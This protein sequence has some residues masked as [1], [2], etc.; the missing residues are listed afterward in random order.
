M[1]YAS[2][3]AQCAIYLTA[4]PISCPTVSAMA[5]RPASV[6]AWFAAVVSLEPSVP[7]RATGVAFNADS[8]FVVRTMRVAALLPSARIKPSSLSHMQAFQ[9]N[10]RKSSPGAISPSSATSSFSQGSETSS[11][12]ISRPSDFANSTSSRSTGVGND[13]CSWAN[14]KP[15]T[16]LKFWKL[17][18]IHLSRLTNFFDP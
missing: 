18:L 2:N 3:S 13:L 6:L 5:E 14:I 7:S 1:S 17:S 15:A 4:A 10:F 9:T 11:S 16:V 8:A 12:P